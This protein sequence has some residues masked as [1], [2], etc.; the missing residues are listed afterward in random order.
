MKSLVLRSIKTNIL[1]TK[2]LALLA[3]FL[4]LICIGLI[5]LCIYQ[6]NHFHELLDNQAQIFQET[7]DKQLDDYLEL[8]KV[9]QPVKNTNFPKRNLGKFN[10]SWYTPVELNKPADKLRT[11]TGSRPKEGRT[12]AVDPKV[13]SYGSTIYIEGYGYFIAEDTGGAI[14]GNR[15]DIFV[16]DYN[17]AKQLGRKTANVWLIGK[18]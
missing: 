4:T 7:L 14:K 10:L 8:A 12:I 2:I 9:E 5:A 6:A 16:N 18:R 13:I 17:K 11:A 15:I 1:T 3:F